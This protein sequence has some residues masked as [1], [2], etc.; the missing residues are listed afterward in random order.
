MNRRNPDPFGSVL[1][2]LALIGL[3]LFSITIGGGL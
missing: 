3:G 1:F 2:W